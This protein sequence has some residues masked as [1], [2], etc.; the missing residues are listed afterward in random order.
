MKAWQ[1]KRQQEIVARISGE[2]IK[3]TTYFMNSNR[4]R[5]E[6]KSIFMKMTLGIVTKVL[7]KRWEYIQ[8][9]SCG[10]CGKEEKM[11]KHVLTS[12][13]RMKHLYIHRHNRVLKIIA[14]RLIELENRK[15]K[16]NYTVKYYQIL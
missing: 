16:L 13:V 2:N 11:L 14:K 1:E 12:C 5:I 9:A 15:K 3:H 7:R 6:E 8:D 4:I 10:M